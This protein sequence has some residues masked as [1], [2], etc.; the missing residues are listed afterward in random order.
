[1]N[2]HY[3][4]GGLAQLARALG[5]YP[6]GRW[7]KSVSRYQ[8]FGP[9][10]NRLRHRPFTAKWAVQL[11]LGSPQKKPCKRKVFYFSW[12][13][14]FCKFFILFFK[15]VFCYSFYCF[16]KQYFCKF[17]HRFSYY[18]CF[19]CYFARFHHAHLLFLKGFQFVVKVVLKHY[20]F[21]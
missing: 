11:C 14:V 10:V 21:S 2:K 12:K 20:L 17:S 13:F 19:I 1:M 9:M 16:A 3:A 4:F 18:F 15:I 6:I 8:Q 7:F 5:S